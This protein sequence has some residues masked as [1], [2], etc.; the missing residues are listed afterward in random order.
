LLAAVS[1]LQKF[2]A[3]SSDDTFVR[4]AWYSTEG[5]FLLR[6]CVSSCPDDFGL[7]PGEPG[8]DFDITGSEDLAFAIA[9]LVPGSTL[10]PAGEFF[11]A[12]W[13]G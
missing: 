1:D 11:D 8:G 6:W 13:A 3:S 7:D 12:G 5:D 2:M 4:R 9:R 10:T